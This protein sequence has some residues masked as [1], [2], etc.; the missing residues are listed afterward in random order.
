MSG[1]FLWSG[2]ANIHAAIGVVPWIHLKPR[3]QTP[4]RILV[5]I[6]GINW[7]VT[8]ILGYLCVSQFFTVP[9]ISLSLGL[10]VYGT[11][12]IILAW[13]VMRR[14]THGMVVC[15]CAIVGLGIVSCLGSP[16]FKANEYKLVLEKLG[17]EERIW[18]VDES[19]VDIDHIRVVSHEQAKWL[20]DKVIGS[21]GTLGSRYRIGEY[22]IQRIRNE[23]W[24][25]APLEFRGFWKWLKFSYSPGFVMVSAEDRNKTPQLVLNRK[26][27]YLPSAYFNRDLLRY[28]YLNGFVGKG[29]NEVTLE[30]DENADPWWVITVFTV[31][32]KY[33]APIVKGVVI[34]NPETGSMKYYPVG[35]IPG[36]VDRV[37]PR[38]F[39]EKYVRWHGKYIKGFW[40]SLLAEE[41]V[42]IPTGFQL[43]WS[44]RGEPCWFTG[45]TSPAKEDQSL[46][47]ILLVN[48]RSGRAREYRVTG[49]H[50]EAVI[51][52]VNSAVSNYK[53]W[54]ATEPILY[55]VFGIKTWVVP[56]I[57]QDGILQSIAMV[58]LESARVA[59][60]ATT[61]E[62]L[63]NYKIMLSTKFSLDVSSS[64]TIK[65]I[66]GRVSRIGLEIV[67]GK[68]LYYI[69]LDEM[70]GRV[71]VGAAEVGDSL[72]VTRVGDA[73]ELKYSETGTG[74]AISISE[75][76]N[77]TLLHP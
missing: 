77:L 37:Y 14:V 19:P 75:F 21:A 13:S 39:V 67:G 25:V 65:A 76:K 64:S 40:N 9:W 61:R 16:M 62:A 26:L 36:W 57:S 74:F 7:F 41:G 18:E 4:I 42:K 17:I 12:N 8:H 44:S 60:G 58:H 53:G 11:A 30:I 56:V 49:P 68:T 27:V 15:W 33:F 38:E 23:L 70:P 22:T 45:L 34:V 2:I 47:A 1:L 20:G 72:P 31:G 10:L 52:A 55:N 6:F 73:V 54:Y 5:I 48:S 3:E 24:W 50:A 32:V 59:L 71:F 29:L 51:Q 69:C 43:V 66:K 63:T 35:E 28:V 46:V